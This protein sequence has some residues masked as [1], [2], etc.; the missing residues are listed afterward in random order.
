[1]AHI[2]AEHEPQLR[3]IAHSTPKIIKSIIIDS[4]H[5]LLH[6]ICCCAFNILSRN[7]P[8]SKEEISELKSIASI[9]HEF[10]D[11]RYNITEKRQHFSKDNRCLNAVKL[12]VIIALRGYDNADFY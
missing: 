4:H 12:I 1:M 3:L 2:I 6:C 11:H 7:V 9:I 10:S 8:V 5:S